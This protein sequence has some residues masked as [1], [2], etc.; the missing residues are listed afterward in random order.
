RPE[1]AAVSMKDFSID[2]SAANDFELPIESS[3]REGAG[4]IRTSALAGS[5]ASSTFLSG[6]V[7]RTIAFYTREFNFAARPESLALIGPENKI[8]FLRDV[9]VR[10]LPI[11]LYTGDPITGLGLPKG[12]STAAE[13]DP[14]H[15]LAAVGCSLANPDSFLSPIDLSR[16]ETAAEV[17]RRAP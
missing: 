6:E 4:E 9:L 10:D 3:I 7:T 15:L 12:A 17:R 2:A 13:S 14:A 5:T 1:S 11:P 8:S 16:Q